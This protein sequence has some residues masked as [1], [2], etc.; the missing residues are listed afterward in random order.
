MFERCLRVGFIDKE[1]RPPSVLVIWCFV[2]PLARSNYDLSKETRI[3]FGECF[4]C[5]LSLVLCLT[6]L[7]LFVALLPKPPNLSV[8][9]VVPLTVQ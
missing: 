7:H 3:A 4:G 8:V 9:D 2:E 5:I 1:S 6:A